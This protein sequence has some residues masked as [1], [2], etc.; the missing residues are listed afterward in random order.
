MVSVFLVSCGQG[1]KSVSRPFY[2]PID[3]SDTRPPEKDQYKDLGDYLRGRERGIIE[4]LNDPS[5]T[6]VTR[7]FGLTT[8]KQREFPHRSPMAQSVVIP[9]SSWW[10]PKREA[11]FFDNS[12]AA[13]RYDY[14]NLSILAKLDLYQRAKEV[15]S[16][17]AAAEERKKFSDESLTWEGLC[18]AWAI[19]AITFPEPLHP[20]TVSLGSSHHD[21]VSFTVGELKGLLLKTI[22]AADE[23]GFKYYGQKFTGQENAWIYPDVFPEQFHR[24]IEVQ[25]FERKQPF[26]VDIDPGVEVWNFPV[27]KANYQM[28]AIPD[29]PNAVFVRM[30]IY[31]ADSLKS[32]DKKFIGTKEIVRE[33]DYVL[34]GDRDANGD[35]VVTYG[36]WVKSKN[37]VDSRHDHPDFLVIPPPR[38]LLYRKSWNSSI[39]IERVDELLERAY[40]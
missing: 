21:T 28:E 35:L 22:E 40:K 17:S 5:L 3:P 30:W 8:I 9:W 11:T 18:D 33:Y 2:N 13:N 14:K 4:E 7:E 34:E 12:R 6:A 26:I 31:L 24:L 19:A 16:P 1:E 20:V 23:N 25:L 38:D 29:K 32:F 10:F 15:N 37:G 27:Y 36:Y 39:S